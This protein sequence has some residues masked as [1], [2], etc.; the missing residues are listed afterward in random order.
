M[1][2][3]LNV[4]ELADK[5]AIGRGIEPEEALFLASPDCPFD[6]LMAGAERVRKAHFGQEASLCGIINARSGACTSDCRYCAQSAHVKTGAPLYPLL[7]PDRIL[8]EAKALAGAGVRCFGI[9]T[10]GPG[11]TPAEV[12]SV[13]EAVR[14][15]KAETRME[16]SA[17]LGMLGEDSLRLLKEAGT[18][19]YHHN[20]ET[21]R[22]FF[23]Q[24]CTTHS[25]DARL[26]TLRRAQ[27]AGLELCS[28]GLFGMGESW[29]DRISLALAL[30]GL[31][32]RSVPINFLNPVPG[33]PLGSRPLMAAEE[34][35]RLVAL[36]RFLLPLATLRICGGRAVTL[37]ER[38]RDI[39]KAGAN[40]FMTGNYLTTPGA[41]PA[42]DLS[43]ARE[44][45]MHIETR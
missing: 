39:F 4:D 29:A 25:W 8:S 43:W 14:R 33:T 6:G 1:A 44:E 28:G 17:S 30:R 13:A 36:F 31:D 40:A 7:D 37:G 15:I 38:Q 24:I 27:A 2:K 42:S 35:L 11:A 22:E 20:L 26:A 32:V 45:G 3:R 12:R 23:P 41:L 18:D 16:V 34:A 10:S 19:R 9:V 21:S 5:A